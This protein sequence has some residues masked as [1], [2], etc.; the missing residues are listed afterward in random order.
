[1]KLF[2]LLF[3]ITLLTSCL[4]K[5]VNFNYF[6]AY[7]TNHWVY[8]DEVIVKNPE[9]FFAAKSITSPQMTWKNL[10]RVSL[11]NVDHCLLYRIP[12]KRLS[13]GRGVLKVVKLR[14]KELCSGVLE[15]NPEVQIE[16]LSH[17]KI[18]YTSKLERNLISKVT[19]RP[20]H[21][22]ISATRPGDKD[23]AFILPLYNVTSGKFI[24]PNKLS[25]KSKVYKKYDSPWQDTLRP[26][27]GL[28]APNQKI[29]SPIKKSKLDY[30]EENYKFCY[31]VDRTCK[32]VM[33]FECQKCKN[34]WYSIVDFKC[35]KGG[36]K[37]CGT[38]SCGMRN[39]P[40]CPRGE[41]FEEAGDL[42]FCF[43]G[44]KAGICQDGLETYCDGNKVLI[45]R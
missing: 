3:F 39:Q 21:L 1:M 11:G 9:S 10:L 31:R 35:N 44:S 40:A 29:K 20:F 37:L 23:W 12:H 17:L 14:K 36:S 26:G 41:S 27:F 4:K 30:S 7:L 32:I 16:G 22:Y 13:K 8:A 25:R 43:R 19:Y 45:C 24:N 38:S 6:G 18:Y 34:G 5:E 15:R 42:N 2:T 28:L 33:N